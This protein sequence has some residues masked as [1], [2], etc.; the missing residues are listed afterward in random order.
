MSEKMIKVNSMSDVIK[1]IS[2]IIFSLITFPCV[3]RALQ[4]ENV[5][6]LFT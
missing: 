3:S 2:S 4:P 1:S 5:E 6:K